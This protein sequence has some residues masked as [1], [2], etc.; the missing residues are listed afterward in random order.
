MFFLEKHAIIVQAA[1]DQMPWPMTSPKEPVL[2]DYRAPCH[3][4]VNTKDQDCW[5]WLSGD[6][7]IPSDPGTGLLQE[8]IDQIQYR[9]LKQMYDEGWF[10]EPSTTYGALHYLQSVS[11]GFH[12]NLITLDSRYCFWNSHL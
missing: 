11:T 5:V 2:D 12:V 10:P 7:A 3:Y 1:L 6:R 8:F 4:I 9:H